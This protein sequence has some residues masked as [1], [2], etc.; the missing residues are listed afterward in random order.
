MCSLTALERKLTRKI[1]DVCGSF[2]KKFPEVIVV[3]HE[4]DPRAGAVAKAK[5]K[6]EP[7]PSSNDRKS[8][9]KGRSGDARAGRGASSATKAAK[10]EAPQSSPLP[11]GLVASRKASNPRENPSPD[12]DPESLT[13]G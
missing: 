7:V 1:G 5:N 8:A 9:S 6:G 3:M 12:A 4:K 11:A 10:R 2:N 13:Y